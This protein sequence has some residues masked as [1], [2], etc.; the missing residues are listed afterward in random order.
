MA[1]ASLTRIV[2][3]CAVG[4]ALARDFRPHRTE[5]RG[6]GGGGR[7]EGASA[8]Q[9]PIPRVFL[10]GKKRPRSISQLTI[11]RHKTVYVTRSMIQAGFFSA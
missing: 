6:G 10:R 7:A 9:P 4:G 11:I 3:A 8:K 1:V 2:C 5:Y